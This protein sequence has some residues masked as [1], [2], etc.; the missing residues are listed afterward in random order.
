MDLTSMSEQKSFINI[1]SMRQYII[2]KYK[3]SDFQFA[4]YP[5]ISYDPNLT[6]VRVEQFTWQDCIEMFK[7]DI[8]LKQH[9]IEQNKQMIEYFYTKCSKLIATSDIEIPIEQIPFLA[10]QNGRLQICKNIYFPS[11]MIDRTETINTSHLYIHRKIFV[12]LN[13]IECNEIKAWLEKLGV[14]ERTDITYLQKTIIPNVATYITKENAIET[15]KMLFR[16]FQKNSITKK[17]FLQLKQM[18]LLTTRENLIPANQCF[19]SDQYNP[20]LKLEE[21]LKTKEDKFLTFDYVKNGIYQR[22]NQ[23]LVEWRRFFSMMGVQEEL[24]LIEFQQ[25]ITDS[26]AVEY[27]FP[28]DYLS[29]CT[30]NK[31]QRIN[32]FSGFQTIPFLHHTESK[33]IY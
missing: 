28:Y 29:R 16:L 24:H 19:F 31:H 25:K 1:D 9:S 4:D 23:D 13:D 21:Y 2:Q 5:F 18:K 6:R 10:D 7:S 8:F 22:E 12:W 33:Y 17:D 11:A 3:E 14:I 15:I 20:R 26:E 30:H 32:A 27:G